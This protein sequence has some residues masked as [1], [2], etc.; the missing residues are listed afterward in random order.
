MISR[1]M[2]DL[3]SMTF[4]ILWVVGLVVALMTGNMS[5]YLIL[6][7]LYF[8]SRAVAR[9]KALQEVKGSQIDSGGPA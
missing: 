2:G 5:M 1:W 6:S 4:L 3:R 9:R 8:G 7:A